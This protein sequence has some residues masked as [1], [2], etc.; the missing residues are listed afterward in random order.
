MVSKC[1]D[2]TSGKSSNATTLSEIIPCFIKPKESHYYLSIKFTV[3]DYTPL[4]ILTSILVRP[5]ASFF[6]DGLR[7]IRHEN[8]APNFFSRRHV[9]QMNN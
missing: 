1:Y 3:K 8:S 5:F 9:F 2:V 4:C 6:I 7:S